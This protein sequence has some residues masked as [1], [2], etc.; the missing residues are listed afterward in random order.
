MTR[1][2]MFIIKA[3]DVSNQHLFKWMQENQDVTINHVAQSEY[4]KNRAF[5][6]IFYTEKKE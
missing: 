1:I 2:A 3:D 4:G 6:T 5:L